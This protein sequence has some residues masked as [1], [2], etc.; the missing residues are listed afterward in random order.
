M[1]SYSSARSNVSLRGNMLVA[2]FADANPPVLWQWTPGETAAGFALR[3]A[4]GMTELVK[5][6]SGG[7]AAVVATF[8]N[9]QRAARALERLSNALM[10]QKFDPYGGIGPDRGSI[11]ST[12]LRWLG[13]VAGIVLILCLLAYIAVHMFIS[14][15]NNEVI[16]NL[17]GVDALNA[18]RASGQLPPSSLP[19][20]GVPQRQQ[21]P[22]QG[23]P[24]DADSI[25]H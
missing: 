21:P 20:P 16:G 11:G 7:G 14:T 22:K 12:L 10:K 3:P 23:E 15:V 4:A 19:L 24:L 6:E 2:W 17:P 8:P 13:A 5:H 18:A 1:N 25:L 9:E